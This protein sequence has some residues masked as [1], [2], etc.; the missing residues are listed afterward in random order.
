MFKILYKICFCKICCNKITKFVVRSKNAYNLIDGKNLQT[1]M[2]LCS[3]PEWSGG[4]NRR[5]TVWWLR[6]AHQWQTRLRFCAWKI[7]LPVFETLNLKTKTF[8]FVSSKFCTKKVRSFQ[9]GWSFV[10]RIVNL[11]RKKSKLKIINYI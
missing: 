9:I 10:C 2:V 4:W 6:R 8:L 3:C 5:P 11:S 1:P 7:W